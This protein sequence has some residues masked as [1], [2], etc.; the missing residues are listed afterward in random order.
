M[1]RTTNTEFLR[2]LMEYSR[3]GA[4]S[5]LFIMDALQ[6]QAEGVAATPLEDLRAAFG[7]NPFISPEAWHMAAVE[8]AEA[9][10][11]R[12]RYQSEKGGQL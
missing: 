7:E 9:F 12:T 10:K 3:V 2:R 6:K 1:S 11:Q 4:M 5:Q 8:I